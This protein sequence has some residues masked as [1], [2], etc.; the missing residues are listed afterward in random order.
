[1]DEALMSK[2]QMREITQRWVERDVIKQLY[3]ETLNKSNKTS[4]QVFVLYVIGN[5]SESET[6]PP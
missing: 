1:M 2:K 5:H 4:A 3:R 6:A